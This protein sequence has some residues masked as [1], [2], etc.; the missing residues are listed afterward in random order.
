M[1]GNNALNR[2][3]EQI[4]I[5]LFHKNSQTDVKRTFCWKKGCNKESAFNENPLQIR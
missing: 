2:Y 1:K 4:L 5:I 3:F